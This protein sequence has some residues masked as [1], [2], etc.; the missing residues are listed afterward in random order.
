MDQ[1]ELKKYHKKKTKNHHLSDGH[2]LAF[3]GFFFIIL[4]AGRKTA[5]EIFDNGF[6]EAII[7]RISYIYCAWII[8]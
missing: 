5:T 1:Y 6:I 8:V 7:K 2:N 4:I 3:L